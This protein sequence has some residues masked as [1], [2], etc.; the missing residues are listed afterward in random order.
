LYINSDGNA[1]I[2]DAN[3]YDVNGRL[4]S[5]YHLEETSKRNEIDLSNIAKGVY[6]LNIYSDAAFITKKIVLE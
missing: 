6:F 2:E 4:I 3:L 5:N 1:I